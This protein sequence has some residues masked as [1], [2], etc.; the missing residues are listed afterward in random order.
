MNIL[1]VGYGSMGKRRIRLLKKLCADV[2]FVCVDSNSERLSQIENDGYIGYSNL[3]EALKMQFDVAFICTSP[4]HH[5]DLLL[6][7]ISAG[8]NVFTELNLVSDKYD[9]IVSKAK[10]N[11]V[12]V[13][14]MKIYI[15][16]RNFQ[17]LKD[18]HQY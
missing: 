1:V 2:S 18:I 16:V 4:G 13:G 5:A 14:N 3:E 17:L 8:I 7:I 12:K 15:L 9:E 11:N 6:Q 10:E